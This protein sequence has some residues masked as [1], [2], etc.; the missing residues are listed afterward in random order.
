MAI[1]HPY[2]TRAVAH[3]SPQKFACALG[4]LWLGIPKGFCDLQL[5]HAACD[6]TVAQRASM[7]VE[8]KQSKITLAQE[9]KSKTL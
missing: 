5:W 3:Y 8:A 6:L 7:L 2:K 1:K 9:R 4:L